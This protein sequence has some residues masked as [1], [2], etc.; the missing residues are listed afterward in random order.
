[1]PSEVLVESNSTAAIRYEKQSTLRYHKDSPLLA[2]NSAM[3]MMK[4]PFRG[5]AT[6]CN[7][8]FI[9]GHVGDQHKDSNLWGFDSAA[10]SAQDLSLETTIK[11]ETLMTKVF[12]SL[13]IPI[14]V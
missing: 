9:S 14:N 4:I 11:M 2:V 1:M 13:D 3:E 10:S 8:S 5:N 7:L 6:T 12:R